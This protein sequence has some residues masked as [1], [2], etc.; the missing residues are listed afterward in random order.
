MPRHWLFKS[1]GAVFSITDLARVSSTS[2]DGVRNYQARN[3]LRDDV[4]V[5]DKVLVYHSNSEPTG[6]AGVAVVIKQGHPDLTAFD[7]KHEHFDPKSVRENPTWYLVDL[8]H[9]RTFETVV[10]RD[11]LAADPV[12]KGMMVMKKGSRLSIQPVTADEFNAVLRL[13]K[14]L[15]V[16]R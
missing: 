8:R 3:M 11:R 9:E 14:P 15:E 1:E 6:I 16:T 10:T 13:A 12:A 5:G 4:R 2:W 7:K